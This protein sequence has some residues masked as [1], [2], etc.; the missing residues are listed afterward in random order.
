[1]S[2]RKNYSA[3]TLILCLLGVTVLATIA[4]TKHVLQKQ[5]NTARITAIE[6]SL[7]NFHNNDIYL[8]RA[9]KALTQDPN[10]TNVPKAAQDPNIP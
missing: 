7:I 4:G 2:E 3:V 10:V 5:S 1:M 8:D 6:K 9:I